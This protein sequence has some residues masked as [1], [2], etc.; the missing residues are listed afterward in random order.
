MK[1]TTCWIPVRRSEP[2]QNGLLR[3]LMV[4]VGL[5]AL[6]ISVVTVHIWTRTKG[7]KKRM[8]KNLIYVF[9]KVETELFYDAVMLVLESDLF[10]RRWFCSSSSSGG[11]ASGS[12]GDWPARRERF[13]AN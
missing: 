6:I 12:G 8:R 10:F 1:D 2:Q 13:G 5:A 3:V 7:G 4:S 11:P 9:L